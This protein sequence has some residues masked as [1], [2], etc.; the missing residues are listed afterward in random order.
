MIEVCVYCNIGDEFCNYMEY[1]FRT[2]DTIAM[3]TSKEFFNQIKKFEL[4]W[5]PIFLWTLN[6][7]INR[8]I[9]ITAYIQVQICLLFLK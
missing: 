7:I 6:L 8:L 3:F 9:R 2:V 1:V 5:N 4:G